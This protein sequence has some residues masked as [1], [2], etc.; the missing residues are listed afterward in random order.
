MNQ[1]LFE[2]ETHQKESHKIVTKQVN[3]NWN[4]IYDLENLGS[5]K[6]HTF[7]KI[8][9]QGKNIE[10]WENSNN[11]VFLN[12]VEICVWDEAEMNCFEVLLIHLKNT[13]TKFIID[14]LL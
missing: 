9:V 4:Q 12:D 6:F 10:V 5:E 14:A 3:M 13:V 11:Q 2:V 7:L 8:N 1:K